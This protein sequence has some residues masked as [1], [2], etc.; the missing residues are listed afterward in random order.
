MKLF[1]GNIVVHDPEWLENA[2]EG[3]TRHEQREFNVLEVVE[4][5]TAVFGLFFIDKYKVNVSKELQSV[6]EQLQLFLSKWN[7]V[8]PWN[9]YYGISTKMVKTQQSMSYILGSL[10]VDDNAEIEESFLVGILSQFTRQLKNDKIFIKIL[11]TEGDFLMADCHESI[12]EEYEYPIATNRLWLNLGHFIM[13][14]KDI[15]YPSRGL[16]LDESIDFLERAFFKCVKIT[17][18]TDVLDTKYDENFCTNFVETKLCLVNMTLKNKKYYEYLKQNSRLFTPILK[19][20]YA[21]SSSPSGNT[22]REGTSSKNESFELAL[23][24]SSSYGDVLTMLLTS[25]NVS[26]PSLSQKIGDLVDKSLSDIIRN[27]DVDFTDECGEESNYKINTSYIPEFAKLPLFEP[28]LKFIDNLKSEENTDNILNQLNT[29]LEKSKL[30]TQEDETKNGG[31]EQQTDEEV[32]EDEQARNY[33]EKEGT[34]INEDDFFEF[35]L[36][37]A[38]KLKSEDLNQFR[39]LENTNAYDSEVPE[40]DTFQETDKEQEDLEEMEALMQTMMNNDKTNSSSGLNDLLASLQIDG[41]MPG[42][43]QSILENLNSQFND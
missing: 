17:G 30:Q 3:D 43:L 4:K 8:F 27:G 40:N 34:G 24:T 2:T 41:S 28:N 36:K 31:R 22:A 10:C 7:E 42:P 20:A 35:F 26:E 6:Y 32:D 12:P 5:T 9:M 1:N 33:F 13:I 21:S 11:D 18:I 37:N 39:N 15:Y 38:L 19:N 14:P 29:Y 25:G 23:P 16:T